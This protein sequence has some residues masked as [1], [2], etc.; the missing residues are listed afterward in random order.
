VPGIALAWLA[1]LSLVV[2]RQVS[3]Q[4]HP[5]V[6]G[7]LL[8]ASGFFAL[9]A[10]AAEIPG[11]RPAATLAAWA[12]VIAAY[13]KAPIITPASSTAAPATGTTQAAGTTTAAGR[14]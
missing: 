14:G 7:T 5:P 4:H 11:A 8:G 13:L 2:Y 10:L 6:P 3:K 12:L 1:G 9:T